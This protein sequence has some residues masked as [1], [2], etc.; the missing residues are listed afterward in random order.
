MGLIDPKDVLAISDRI[1]KR[2]YFNLL[3]AVSGS[4]DSGSTRGTDFYEFC[5]VCPDGDAEIETST[6]TQAEASDQAWNTTSDP[7]TLATSTMGAL[8]SSYSIIGAL[9]THF[10]TATTTA[11]TRAIT[12]SW[13]QYL[14]E[15]DGTGTIYANIPTIVSAGTGVR[16]SE[17]F[18][19]VFS[20][21]GGPTLRARNVFYD[22]PTP[23]T[24]ATVTGAASNQVVLNNLGD[25]GTGTSAVNA[26]GS[27][28]AATRMKIHAYTDWDATT[29]LEF[30]MVTEP[31]G[32]T[33]T[34][35]VIVP[36]MTAGDEIYIGA[37]D[38]DRYTKINSVTV[39]DGTTTLNQV[40]MVQNVFERVIEL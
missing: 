8:S 3:A 28:F 29:T 12:G 6:L 18:R 21:A 19:R 26:D 27:N 30:T 13:N 16:V 4:P 37:A 10:N 39:T 24:F 17:Y 35:S 14:E 11:G 32:D 34:V 33:T 15:S 1:G 7:F 38:T 5:H 9:T 40:L 25:F 2:Y 23:F 20:N 31:N 36:A 22:S